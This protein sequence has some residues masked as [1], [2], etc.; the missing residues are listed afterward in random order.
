MNPNGVPFLS[1]GMS[2][3]AGLM[4]RVENH[5]GPHVTRRPPPGFTQLPAA[6]VPPPAAAGP[7]TIVQP[8]PITTAT[9]LPSYDE[10]LQAK[11]S[12]IVKPPMVPTFST[13]TTQQQQQLPQTGIAEAKNLNYGNATSENISETLKILLHTEIRSR[14]VRSRR[15][16]LS[17]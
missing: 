11:M 10:A 2:P 4:S 5:N 8:N 14:S 16:L 1:Y 12:S 7:G 9:A 6:V 13:V 17:S 3:D 15:I